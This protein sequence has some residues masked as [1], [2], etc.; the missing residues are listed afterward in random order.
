[1]LLVWQELLQVWVRRVPQALRLQV[2]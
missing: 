2:S 1:V